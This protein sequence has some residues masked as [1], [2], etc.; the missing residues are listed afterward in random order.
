MT[1]ARWAIDIDRD[2]IGQAVLVEEPAPSLAPGREKIPIAAAIVEQ[3]D[4][5][6]ER[7]VSDIVGGHREAVEA[8]LDRARLKRTKIRR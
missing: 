5:L 1:G 7:G 6:A 2:D 8:H 4:R 3:P